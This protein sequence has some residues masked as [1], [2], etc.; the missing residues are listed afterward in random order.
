L[1]NRIA[2]NKRIAL[3]RQAA[4]KRNAEIARIQVDRI[5][6]SREAAMKRKTEKS[7][8]HQAQ[9]EMIA[10]KRKAALKRKAA[11]LQFRAGFDDEDDGFQ[12]DEEAQYDEVQEPPEHEA[13]TEADELED[14]SQAAPTKRRRLTTKQKYKEAAEELE[15][16]KEAVKKQW[17]ERSARSHILAATYQTAVP[18]NHYGS[19]GLMHEVVNELRGPNVAMNAAAAT[20]PFADDVHPSHRRMLLRNILFCKRCGYWSSKKTQRLSSECNLAPPH[21]DGKAKLKR[22]MEGF[23][24][25][26][27][28]QAWNDG[29]STSI[30]VKPIGLDQ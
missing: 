15:R 27:N 22:M 16:N 28:V 12:H 24:P 23:H 13:T 21:S 25:D 14:Q 20:V 29:L 1:R 7:E 30:N 5:R 2:K 19:S 3:S 11:R 6:E 26:R 18:R 9:T 10:E 8:K 17:A 4:V